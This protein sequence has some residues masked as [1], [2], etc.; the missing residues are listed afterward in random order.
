[1]SLAERFVERVIEDWR[2]G[3]NRSRLRRRRLETLLSALIV[4]MESC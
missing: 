2:E 4:R 3:K 1:V